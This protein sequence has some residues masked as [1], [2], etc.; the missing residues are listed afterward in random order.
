MGLAQKRDW[1]QECWSYTPHGERRDPDP[2][3]TVEGIDGQRIRYQRTQR[4]CRKGPV[5]EQQLAPRLVH[6]RPAWRTLSNRQAIDA[7]ER[8]AFH[9]SDSLFATAYAQVVMD[10]Y[11]K[12]S[13]IETAYS[14]IK[15]KFGSAL[16]S[17]S[18]TGQINEALCKVLCHNLCVLV[19]AMHELGIKPAF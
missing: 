9:I 14:M 15:G 18:D 2:G 5:Q 19:Q 10:H 4:L 17:K 7:I 8:L 12:W 6:D 16:R 1:W 13:N 11:H 3:S